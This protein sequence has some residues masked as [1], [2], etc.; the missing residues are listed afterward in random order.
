MEEQTSY[1]YEIVE[2]LRTEYENMNIN[3]AREIMTAGV[4]PP[5]CPGASSLRLVSCI[6]TGV[7]VIVAFFQ[8][9]TLS[10]LP[11]IPSAFTICFWC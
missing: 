11:P 7:T 2:V 8:I 4:S 1:L 6:S 3:G 10:P 5:V 9:Q